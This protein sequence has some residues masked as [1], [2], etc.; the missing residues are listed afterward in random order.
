M[1]W[2]WIFLIGL[3]SLFSLVTAQQESL[4]TVIKTKI[5]KEKCLRKSRKGD[6]VSVE[7]VGKLLDGTV[8]DSS[9]DNVIPF[10][11]VLG[12][13]RVIKGWDLGIL[14]MCIGEERTLTISPEYAYGKRGAGP[15]PSE[16]T[17]IFDVKLLSIAGYKP[18]EEESEIVEPVESD[19]EAHDEL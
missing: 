12:A 17:L 16:A 4:K 1:R 18:E 2:N 14:G 15:I 19:T 5:P 13:G 7:Y 8:F 9:V 10:R 6:Q 11:F 3:I